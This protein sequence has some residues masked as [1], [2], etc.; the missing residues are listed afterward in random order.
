M[1]KLLIQIFLLVDSV[2]A[3]SKENDRK[4]L[5]SLL[6]GD[7]ILYRLKDNRKV[8]VCASINSIDKFLVVFCVI[9]GEVFDSV[10]VGKCDELLERFCFLAE[11]YLADLL[12]ADFER[13]NRTASHRATAVQALDQ[14]F[15]LVV[16]NYRL[17]C[18]LVKELVVLSLREVYLKLDERVVRVDWEVFANYVFVLGLLYH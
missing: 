13:F 7:D 10:I 15:S 9:L 12:R 18:V 8:C 1:V 3:I 5:D 6:S 14:D 2:A 16:N 4:G 11:N 17:V